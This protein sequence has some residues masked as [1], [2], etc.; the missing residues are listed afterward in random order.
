MPATS[1][2]DRPEARRRDPILLANLHLRWQECAL[3]DSYV[4]V[5][6]WEYDLSLH[7]VSRHPRDDVEANLVMLCG[8][9]TTGCHGRVEARDPETLLE[10]VRYI[11]R[12]R[13]DI[14]KYLDGKSR[15]HVLE[16]PRR[17][18]RWRRELLE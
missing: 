15:A 12:H 1:S 18:S 4:H 14:V 3:A 13:P 8:S 7:H 16:E 6:A 11:R 10:L 9:G 17:R 2:D 5:R